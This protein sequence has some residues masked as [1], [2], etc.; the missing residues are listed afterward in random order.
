MRIVGGHPALNLANTVEPRPPSPP[1]SDRATVPPTVIVE[2]DHLTTPQA[3]LAWAL[4]A[5]VVTEPEAPLIAAAWA[6]PL[7]TPPPA[8]PQPAQPQ[9]AQPQSAQPQPAPAQPAPSPL[10]AGEAALADARA[11]RALIDPVLAGAR[12]PELTHRWSQAIARSELIADRAR[13]ELVADRAGAD[14]AGADRAG[15]ELVADREAPARAHSEPVA[16][17]DAGPAHL[18]VGTDP[19]WMIPDRL[20]DALVDLV[21]TADRSRL[22]TCPLDEGGCGWLFLDRSR[23]GTRRWCSMEDCGTHVKARRLTERRRARRTGS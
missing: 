21:R 6:L 19:A 18:R 7:P 13:S 16:A 23:N 20:A 3:L 12:L 8:Q 14:R 4:L 11:L 5:G 10:E 2:T 22:R 9:P 1:L 17:R 15:A